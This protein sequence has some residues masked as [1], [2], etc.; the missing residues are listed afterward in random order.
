MTFSSSESL[1][2]PHEDVID[3]PVEGVGFKAA[4]ILAMIFFST[5]MVRLFYNAV[6]CYHH[7]V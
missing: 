5:D 2:A 7:Q 6:I 4:V 3:F 1:D